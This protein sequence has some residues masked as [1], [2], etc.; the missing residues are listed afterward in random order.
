MGTIREE[1][2]V[3][4]FKIILNKGWVKCN[5]LSDTCEHR[6]SAYNIQQDVQPINEQISKE[7]AVSH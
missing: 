7:E 3:T 1:E 4:Y 2:W 6:D 5:I